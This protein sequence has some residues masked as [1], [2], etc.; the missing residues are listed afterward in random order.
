M[1]IDGKEV[2]MAKY[3][4][5]FLKRNPE[6]GE[7]CEI[8]P[9]IKDTKDSISIDTELNPEEVDFTPLIERYGSLSLV[10]KEVKVPYR[11]LDGSTGTLV[12]KK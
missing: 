4:S 3:K 8:E 9:E 2:V 11:K 1:R 10:P 12:I 5:S 7:W 6:T